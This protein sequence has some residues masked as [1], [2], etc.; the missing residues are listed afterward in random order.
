MD[1]SK[2]DLIY[3]RKINSLSKIKQKNLELNR[4][5]TKDFI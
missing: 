3:R 4:L 1:D 2:M 5:C